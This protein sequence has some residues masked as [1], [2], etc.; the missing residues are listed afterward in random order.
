M[1]LASNAIME[2]VK[3]ARLFHSIGH[4]AHASACGTISAIGARGRWVDVRT[5]GGKSVAAKLAE[6]W[7]GN[8]LATHMRQGIAS[9]RRHVAPALLLC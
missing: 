8:I 5:K 4:A 2:W 6:K 9:H 7:A 1:V 3:L